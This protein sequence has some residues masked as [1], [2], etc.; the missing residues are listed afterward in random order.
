MVLN[1]TSYNTSLGETFT[2][3]KFKY[4]ISNIK[5]GGNGSSIAESNSNHLIDESV[6]ASRSFAFEVEENT[7]SGIGFLLGVDSLRNVSGAQTGALDPLND[8]FWTWN[9][10]YVMA[11]MEGTSPQ[12]NQFGNRIEYHLGGFAGPDNVVRQVN[13]NLPAPAVIKEGGSS[14]I[15]IDADL[16]TWWQNPYDLKI[17]NLPVCTTPGPEA[18][19]M[20]TTIAKCLAFLM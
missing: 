3:N 15:V 1:T 4:Y 9:S 13:L 16:N 12:S 17:V 11:K 20:Q 2:V 19:K 8:M 18:K 10:G 7:F 5:A 14:E 6:T